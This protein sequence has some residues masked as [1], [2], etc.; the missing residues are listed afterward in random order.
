MSVSTISVTRPVGQALERTRAILFRPF[1]AAKWFTLGFCAWL[2]Q[3]GRSGAGG[4]FNHGYR[5]HAGGAESLQDALRHTIDYAHRNLVWI[6][7]L[8]AVL[9]LLLLALWVLFLWLGSRGRFMFLDGVVHNRGLVV[10]P[11]RHHR[12]QANSL[13]RFRLGLAAAYIVVLWPLLI[14]TGLQAVHAILR[15]V[16]TPADIGQAV[17][18]GLT[19]LFVSLLIGVVAKLTVDFV[20]PVMYL[21]GGRCL[22]AWSEVGR[23]L[24]AH[25]GPI[26]L[27]LLFQIV[28]AIAVAVIVVVAVVATCC[29]GGV[30]LALPY[31]GTVALLPVLVFWRS[32]SLHYLAQYGPDFDVFPPPVAA[33]QPVAGP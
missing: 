30:L 4:G 31:L 16:W 9:I 20:V 5:R 23:V 22:E 14:L 19:A 6:V 15:G 27:Y 12:A 7:P 21:R 17:S 33:P 1:D 26:L 32:Y 24:S 3:L 11:W 10:A 8:A 18:L 13:F 2:A 29:I 25:V 28:L